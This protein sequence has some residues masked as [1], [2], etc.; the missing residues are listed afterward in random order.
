MLW[1]EGLGAGGAGQSSEL[2]L[3]S[4]HPW[5]R[6][7]ADAALYWAPRQAW[8]YF[9]SGGQA[10]THALI[11]HDSRTNC[12]A[13]IASCTEMMIEADSRHRTSFFA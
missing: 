7:P 8:G 9:E 11:L 10:K 4:K 2:W 3:L 1:A 12:T 6:S 13:A 5:V